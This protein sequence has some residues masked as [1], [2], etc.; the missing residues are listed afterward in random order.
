[1]FFCIGRY[2]VQQ[3]TND[4]NTEFEDKEGGRSWEKDNN[5]PDKLKEAREINGSTT[6]TVDTIVLVF[7]VVQGGA[8]VFENDWV[9]IATT[10]TG[11]TVK[12]LKRILNNMQQKSIGTPGASAVDVF[13]PG[14][15]GGATPAGGLV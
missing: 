15:I 1:M 8:G 11:D 12:A 5:D 13:D 10:S 2:L 4:T 7:R 14:I 9:I 3:M 6:L